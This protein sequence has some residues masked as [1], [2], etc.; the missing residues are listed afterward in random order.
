TSSSAGQHCGPSPTPT[1]SN[2][3]TTTP[4]AASAAPSSTASSHSA[5]NPNKANAPS[6]DSS[7][8]R[9]RA[10]SENNRSSPTSP[11]PSPPTPAAT[12]KADLRDQECLRA[13]KDDG[14]PEV[15]V[16]QADRNPS[17]AR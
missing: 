10:D 15:E 5:A 6:N 7:P 17:R 8:P 16:E 11:M 13:D 14:Q 3:P 2:R 4:S 12:R 9:S 1:A